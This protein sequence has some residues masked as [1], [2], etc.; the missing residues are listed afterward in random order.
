MIFNKQ[1]RS[2]NCTLVAASLLQIS[3]IFSSYLVIP[4]DS[5]TAFE[6]IDENP[7]HLGKCYVKETKVAHELG[8]TWQVPEMIC[9]QASCYR[10]GYETKF[11]I[12]YQTCGLVSV[13]PGCEL[14]EDLTVPYPACCPQIRCDSRLREHVINFDTFD[15]PPQT[16]YEESNEIH[17]IRSKNF[18]ADNDPEARGMPNLRSQQSD[19]DIL[20]NNPS[21]ILEVLQHPKNINKDY[22]HDLHAN[23]QATT[24]LFAVI[25]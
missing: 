4:S 15:S 21:K 24:P 12:A 1:T 25:P 13:D 19:S 23:V 9:A 14:I 8:S 20:K 10:S 22:S 7:E 5:A 3:I 11:L 2:I 18:A 6:E 17:S 16:S